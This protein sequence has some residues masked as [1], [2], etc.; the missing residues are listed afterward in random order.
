MSKKQSTSMSGR[1]GGTLSLAMS[2]FRPSHSADQSRVKQG[3]A[4][5]K[6]MN[7]AMARSAGAM[8]NCRPLNAAEMNEVER[9]S[10]MRAALYP[11]D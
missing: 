1:L 2:I 11:K 9:L 4:I 8:P 7:V 6:N 10:S 5:A 3:A